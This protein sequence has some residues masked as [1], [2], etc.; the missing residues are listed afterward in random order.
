MKPLIR[1]F[2]CGTYLDLK[3]ERASVLDAIVRLGLPHQSMEFFGARPQQS[4]ETCLSEVRASDA[5]VII[6]GRR[7][8]NIV[9]GRHVSYSEA[10]YD[11]AYRL[12][13]PCLVYI[14][15]D[16]SGTPAS[17]ER[18]PAKVDLLAQWK[19][20]LSERHTCAFY[21]SAATLAVQ[22][23]IDL[24]RRISDMDKQTTESV[25]QNRNLIVRSCQRFGDSA[26]QLL[27][28]LSI[29]RAGNIVTIGDF[30]G[31]IDF[32]NSTLTSVGNRNIFLAKFDKTGRHIWSR[33]YGNDSE[34]AGV[35]VGIDG[36]GAAYIVSAFSGT[37]DFGGQPLVSSGSYNVGLA[38]IDTAGDH[39]WSKCFG[40][41]RYHVP[42]CIAVAPS[43]RVTIAG[44]FQGTID[45]GGSVLASRSNQTDIFIATFSADGECIWAKGI[46]GPYEQQTRAM[47]VDAVGN[48][49]VT[50]VFKGVLDAGGLILK[51]DQPG[52]YCGFLAKLDQDGTVLWCNRFGEPRVEQGSAIAFDHGNGDLV[53]AG[54]MRNKLPKEL[55]GKAQAV[56]SLTRLDSN[57]VVRW[58]KAFGTNAFA[59]SLSVAPDQEI[60]LTGY[61]DQ[62]VDFGRGRLISAGGYDLFAATFTADGQPN[63]SE[64]YGDQRQQF[65]ITGTYGVDGSIVLGGSFHG[66][67]D[68]GAGVLVAEGYTGA[69]EGAEDVFLTI[70]AGAEALTANQ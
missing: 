7:Y 6:I 15:D 59:S 70:L 65:L 69:A 57:G 8:G 62:V 48:I 54:F 32:G 21:S 63:W 39:I 18:D 34:Q 4:I 28:G 22:V 20:K 52:D 33:R 55:V 11:E 42:E 56:C 13:I 64:R 5:I 49:G 30:W 36:T 17:P 25:K 46:G 67:I 41:A 44:R 26:R 61:F 3:E 35:G 53:A 68:F 12:N 23:A 31:K 27:H 60:L 29:D 37:I 9:P 45:F 51:E 19:A 58:S 14:A 10:E 47:A 50:G 2:V 16:T 24:P 66:T 43:G 1:V 38:K 40:D